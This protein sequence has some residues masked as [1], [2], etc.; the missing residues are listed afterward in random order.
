MEQA[1]DL[2]DLEMAMCIRRV[3]RNFLSQNNLS[4]ANELA[5]PVSSA[6]NVVVVC[7]GNGAGGRHHQRNEADG[8]KHLLFAFENGSKSVF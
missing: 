5:T 2:K 8:S 3:V 4:L 6:C 1:K 7:A